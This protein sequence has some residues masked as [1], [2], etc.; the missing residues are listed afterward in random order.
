MPED[1]SERRW[2]RRA[3]R[4]ALATGLTASCAGNV[5]ED[6]YA[7]HPAGADGSSGASA[8]VPG[9][10]GDGVVDAGEQCDEGAANDDACACATP[11]ARCAKN[12]RLCVAICG[13]GS[14]NPG[15]ACDHGASNGTPGDT[16][17]CDC[18]IAA[19]CGNGAIE[20]GE[21]CDGAAGPCG[22]CPCVACACQKCTGPIFAKVVS[23]MANPLVAGTGLGA[24]WSYA[25]MLGAAAGKAMCQKVGADHP[26]SYG[27]VRKADAQ[28]ELSA[29]PKNLSYWLWRKEYLMDPLAP[30]M[31]CDPAKNDPKHFND[32]PGCD[33]ADSCDP[34]SKLCSYKPGS[35]GRCSDFAGYGSTEAFS[36][37]EWFEV[38]DP[39]SKFVSGGVHLGS[40]DFHFDADAAYDG[41]G[42]HL[43]KDATKVG[44]AGPCSAVPRAMLCCNAIPGT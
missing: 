14:L 37:G 28:G 36:D 9:G 39:S 35:G 3:W 42:Q 2:R 13:N 12:C 26:C 25:G 29:L 1:V 16:C 33:G 7:P 8:T 44:C 19:V 30:N 43:C 27:E 5:I 38:F 32:N 6:R 10:C 4:F 22:V 23:N 15:E 21:Q 17:T 20:A 40:L 24:P 41:G 31:P 18:Q 34:S 11:A